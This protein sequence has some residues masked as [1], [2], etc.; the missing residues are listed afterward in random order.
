[1]GA[2]D[3]GLVVLFDD[4]PEPGDVTDPTNDPR[5]QWICL[6]CLIDEN[7]ELG[8]GLDVAKEWGAADLEDGEWVG[9]TPEPEDVS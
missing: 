5:I 2:I 1:M 8:R 3:S 4:A 9:R 7:P 6:H